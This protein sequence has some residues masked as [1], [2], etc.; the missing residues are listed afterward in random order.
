MTR[1]TSD[2]ITPEYYRYE[3][4]KLRIMRVYAAGVV[5]VE[6]NPFKFAVVAT[7]HESGDCLIN[8]LCNPTDINRD[9]MRDGLD[10]LRQFGAE[11]LVW[12][13]KAKPQSFLPR[14]ASCVALFAPLIVF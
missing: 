1:I 2:D 7:I 11:K 3:Y 14:L 8:A 6:P 10:H 4:P 5:P 9:D 13:H 12:R